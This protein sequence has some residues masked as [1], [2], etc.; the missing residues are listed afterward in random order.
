M[1]VIVLGIP[2]PKFPVL[3]N[4]ACSFYPRCQDDLLEPRRGLRPAHRTMSWIGGLTA[5]GCFHSFALAS[6]VI[7]S[8]LGLFCGVAGITVDS[9][10]W[11]AGGALSFGRRPMRS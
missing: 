1:S 8:R 9:I 11:I 2:V 4:P 7:H 5:A 6:L 10:P 3:G